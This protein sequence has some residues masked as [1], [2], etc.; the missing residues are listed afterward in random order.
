MEAYLF[1]LVALMIGVFA[2]GLSVYVPAMAYVE[3]SLLKANEE[4]DTYREFVAGSIR[5]TEALKACDNLIARLKVRSTWCKR[6]LAIPVA[7]FGIWIFATALTVS[8]DR[9]FD[10]TVISGRQ[11]NLGKTRASNQGPDPNT[12]QESKFEDVSFLCRFLFHRKILMIFALLNLSIIGASLV[13]LVVLKE[14]LQQIRQ[15]SKI[16]SEEAR[17]G[18]ELLGC[19]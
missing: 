10:H 17:G 9:M 1:S 13:F 7:F 14:P 4:A 2:A 19:S 8:F 3:K 16:V 11:E 5:G 18:M 15:I 6:I 12:G